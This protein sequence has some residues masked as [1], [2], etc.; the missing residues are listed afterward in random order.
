MRR[1]DFVGFLA[2][3]ALWSSEAAAQLAGR[4]WRI[5]FLTARSR[6]DTDRGNRFVQG[7]RD[8]GYVHEKDFIVEWRA[9]DGQY[10]RLPGLAEDLVRL[11]VDVIVAQASPAVRAAQR[12]TTTIPIVIANAGDPVAAGF[13]ESLAR[14]GGNI[15][16]LSLLNVDLSA[17]HLEFMSMLV[18]KICR[19]RQV[20]SA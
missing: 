12:A 3:A 16:G 20:S 7:M 6:A 15:T 4:I 17:K 5:G 2:A 8:L 10:E 9:A 1:R 13:V 18:P 19:P 11:K 14:P